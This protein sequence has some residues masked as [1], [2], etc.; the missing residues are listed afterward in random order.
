MQCLEPG[1]VSAAS[2][3]AAA[4]CCAPHIPA[5]RLLMCDPIPS[6][7]LLLP[8]SQQVVALHEVML[9]SGLTPD[10]PT[11]S[12]VLSAALAAGQTRKALDLANSLQVSGCGWFECDALL[13]AWQH[14]VGSCGGSY[15]P[16]CHRAFV[17]NAHR[18]P[19]PPFVQV[20]GFQ[21]DAAVLAHLVQVGFTT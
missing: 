8:P 18:R 13:R 20:Q 5:H 10:A 17:R 12:L 3:G 6:P 16:I 19:N 1:M 15:H 7:L 2:L 9:A 14:S 11:A 21:L 4:M